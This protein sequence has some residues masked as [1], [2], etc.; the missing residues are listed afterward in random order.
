MVSFGIPEVDWVSLVLPAAYVL[1]LGS[2]LFTFS[3]IYRKRKAAQSANLAPWFGPHLQRNIYLSLLHINPEDPSEKG[4]RIPDSVIRAALLRRAV[5]DIH[6]LV[7][8]RT[9]K[10]ACSSL[11]QKGSVG[12]DLWQRFQRAEKEMEDELRDVVMEA[13]ALAPNWGQIIFQSANEI[14]ANTVVRT[15]LDEIQDQVD[16]EKEW[17]EKR[18]GTIQADFMKELDAEKADSTNPPSVDGDAVLVDKKK[19]EA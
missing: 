17:W 3:N 10:Q 7:Q 8:I 14:A 6:R 2:A 19:I 18:R 15:R 12:D 5:E 9:A 4:P 13:N 1:V 16:A 11:L